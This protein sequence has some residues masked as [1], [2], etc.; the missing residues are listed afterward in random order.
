MVL[1][2]ILMAVVSMIATA[3]ASADDALKPG[4][5]I[6][7]M[8]TESVGKRVSVRLDSR[9]ELEGTVTTVGDQLVLIS[10]L[11]GRDYFDAFVSIERISAV[12]VSV[13][14][15][16]SISPSAGSRVHP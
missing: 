11:A 10:K 4:A 8:L 2:A 9:E 3:V 14:A 12:I 6:R 1:L 13:G 15:H 5:T 16:Q 7:S